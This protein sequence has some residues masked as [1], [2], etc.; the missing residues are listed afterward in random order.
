[1]E[2]NTDY[3]TKG[4]SD[5]KTQPVVTTDTQQLDNE[6]HTLLLD[7]QK[8]PVHPAAQLPKGSSGGMRTPLPVYRLMWEILSLILATITLIGLVVLLKTHEDK[9]TP[10]WSVGPWGVTLN[11]VLS[12]VSTIF[13][14]SLLVPVAQ[15]ISQFGWIW[16]TQPRSLEDLVYYS[17][18]SRG[19]LGSLRLLIKLRFIRFASIGAII[20]IATLALDPFFQ[21][22]VR[23]V[24]SSV[25]DANQTAHAVVAYNWGENIPQ[26]GEFVNRYVQI[27]YNMKAAVRNGLLSSNPRSFPSPPFSCPSGNCTWDPFAT[28][29]VGAQ[30]QD[31]TSRVH[32]N[33]TTEPSGEEA[34]S[35]ETTGDDALRDL[36]NGTNTYTVFKI[37]SNMPSQFV[38]SSEA[39]KP[40]RNK[41]A[42][43]ALVQWV[44]VTGSGTN[45]TSTSTFEAVRC[46]FYFA[47]RALQAQVFEGVYSEEVLQEVTRPEPIQGIRDASGMDSGDFFLNPYG[48][49]GPIAYRIDGPPGLLNRNTF[50]LSFDTFYILSSQLVADPDL[51]D[52]TLLTNT[53]GGQAAGPPTP[54]MLWQADNTT[55][56]MYS[57][58]DA[59][60]TQ[61]RADGT[62]TLRQAQDDDSLIDPAQAVAGQVWVQEQIVAVRWAWLVLP[63]VLLALSVLFLAAAFVETRR[64]RVVG[65]WQSSPLT[66]FFHARLPKGLA[67]WH[68]DASATALDSEDAMQRAASRLT[69]RIPGNTCGTIEVYPTNGPS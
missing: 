66:L 8:D 12:I 17:S 3:D 68:D 28:L 36:V 35:F 60:T 62:I 1:M 63:I 26:S 61:M 59:I 58:A 7:E 27:P 15:S 10:E 31:L 11:A 25:I 41:T 55:R 34:C 48:S 37:Q 51:L 30:C 43:L 38:G 32:I 14:G 44:K 46:D 45:V 5:L 16:Y 24:P 53:G 40:Y 13:R 19:P 22:S 23:Y 29:A 42:S 56:A 52:G 4:S 39:M 57:L 65:L 64:A 67:A 54:N 47:A 20:T 33:C 6:S 49:Y 9:P 21:Q 50:E 18:A 69:A 2:S